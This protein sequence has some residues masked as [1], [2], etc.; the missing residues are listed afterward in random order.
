MDNKLNSFILKIPDF[1]NKMASELIVYF[2]YFT[3]VTKQNGFFNI[4]D[5]KDCFSNLNVKP[6][7]NIS[8][9]L[10]K[11]L[12]KKPVLFLKRK[13]GYVITK[14]VEEKI[15]KE[16]SI[17]ARTKASNELIDLS[18]FDQKGVPYYVKSLAEEMAK[19]Y[20]YNLYD[21]VLVLMRKLIETII[22][23]TFEHAHVSNE[24]KDDSGN[25]YSLGI[26]IDKYLNTTYW[27]PSKNLRKNLVVI[28]KYGDLS[29]HNRKFFAKN[30]DI[31][32]IKFELRQAIQELLL[33]AYDRPN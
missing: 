26:L 17:P 16:L 2:A 30:N 15:E 27:N 19:S 22:I 29:A 31:S 5:I 13:E 23:E 6:Y 28:K 12:K 9:F 25:F 1:D 7:S 18:L 4:V 20:D 32:H 3:Q 24:I 8:S 33:T 21:A 10:N 11:H 14:Q